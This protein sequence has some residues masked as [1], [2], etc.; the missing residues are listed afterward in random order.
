[1]LFFGFQSSSFLPFQYFHLIFIPEGRAIRPSQNLFRKTS[2]SEGSFL[3]SLP[4]EGTHQSKNWKIGTKLQFSEPIL[5]FTNFPKQVT[6]RTLIMTFQRK[7]YQKKIRGYKTGARGK[8][9]FLPKFTQLCRVPEVQELLWSK[10][11][12]QINNVKLSKKSPT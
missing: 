3:N 6:R 9:N 2:I 8:Y 10:I 5:I 4:F 1:M 11:F 7:N 12:F